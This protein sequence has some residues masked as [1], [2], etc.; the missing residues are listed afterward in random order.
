MYRHFDFEGDPKFWSQERISVPCDIKNEKRTKRWLMAWWLL[1][2]YTLKIPVVI[3]AWLT[4]LISILPWLV[5]ILSLE[6]TGDSCGGRVVGWV[7]VVVR[8]SCLPRVH[9]WWCPWW[10]LPS[11]S[12][13]AWGQS[14]WPPIGGPHFWLSPVEQVGIVIISYT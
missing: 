5:T 14:V 10:D 12:T 1:R 3:T 7:G 2:L 6:L 13:L 4:S 9:S 8:Q 11:R